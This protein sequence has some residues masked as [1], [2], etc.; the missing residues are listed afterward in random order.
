MYDIGQPVHHHS[1][2]AFLCH[3]FISVFG[4]HMLLR[5]V[6]ILILEP[7]VIHREQF[8]KHLALHLLHKVIYSVSI[9]KA[10][11]FR[12]VGVEIEVKRETVLFA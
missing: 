8:A 11:F 2:T 1:A 9:N 10:P 7:L 6:T 3:I 4:I 5:K 12:I